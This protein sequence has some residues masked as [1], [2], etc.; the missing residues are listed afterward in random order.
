MLLKY[1]VIHLYLLQCLFVFLYLLTKDASTLKMDIYICE[2]FYVCYVLHPCLTEIVQIKFEQIRKKNH[3]YSLYYSENQP[4]SHT[5]SLYHHAIYPLS[6]YHVASVTHTAFLV[7]Q[8]CCRY[9]C[10]VCGMEFR[11]LYNM[12]RHLAKH[13]GRYPYPCHVCPRG[14]NSATQLKEHLT[15]HTK[16]NYF[17][18]HICSHNFPKKKTLNQHVKQMHQ[19]EN[20]AVIE[21]NKLS[22]NHSQSTQEINHAM[23]RNCDTGYFPEKQSV[24]L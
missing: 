10:C 4:L 16:Q 20:T 14:Y 6:P 5:C 11:K 17:P 19:G 7:F 1:F 3:E 15:Q 12:K 22:D 8:P 23:R 24:T 13:S 21:D 2:F 9:T 18:C